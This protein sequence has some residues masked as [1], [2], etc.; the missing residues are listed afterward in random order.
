MKQINLV[1]IAKQ[2]EQDP[3]R[4]AFVLTAIES[5]SRQ[6]YFDKS[7]WGSNSLINKETWQEIAQENLTMLGYAEGG[8]VGYA[9]GGT[10]GENT[11]GEHE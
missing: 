4:K 10:V 7:D 11:E 9:E 6:V 5:Y 1:D 2:M 3:L 8:T